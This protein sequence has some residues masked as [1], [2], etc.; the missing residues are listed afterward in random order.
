[1]VVPGTILVLN[2]GSSSLKA[3][4][5]RWDDLVEIRRDGLHWSEEDGTSANQHA[6]AAAGLL[7]N[8]VWPDPVVA[9]AH[10]IVHAGAQ[11]L[12]ARVD[13]KVRQAIAAHVDLAPLHNPAALAVIQVTEDLLPEATQVAV[14]D[15]GFHNSMEPEA[16]RYAV[17]QQWYQRMGIRRFGFHGLSHAYSSRRAAEMMGGDPATLR[18]VTCHLGAGCSLCACRGGRSVFTT[19]GYT[20]MDGLMMATRSGALDPGALL[21]VLRHGE[22]DV[23]TLSAVLDQQSGLLGVSGVSG[24]MRKILAERENGHP[25]AALA[26]AMY[27]SRLRQGIGALAAEL[28]GVDALVFTGGVGEN[29]PE[30]RAAAL[31]GLQWMGIELD[32]SRNAAAAPDV[33]V[34]TVVSRVRVL[35]VATQEE[36]MAAEA[37]RDLLR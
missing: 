9:V 17:P 28:G 5:F 25:G 13:E 37:T 20:P 26:F 33:D 18:V 16:Y 7:R 3:A 14:F 15:T 32:P 8:G 31:D 2:A 36:R 1:M 27:V 35:V 21:A 11:G 30:V 22:Y 19:M 6:Q 10:R 4:A 29:A 34:A 24:D 12:A 23:E